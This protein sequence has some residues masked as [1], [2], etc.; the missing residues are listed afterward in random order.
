MGA[1]QSTAAHSCLLAA[2]G[3]SSSSVA[4]NGDLLFSS[5]VS[6]YNLNIPVAPIAVTYP[7]SAQ[8]VAKIVKCAADYNLK[9]QAYS[10][11]HSYGNYGLGGTDGAVVVNMKHFR[12]FSMDA[13][14]IATAGPGLNLGELH[15][16]LAAEGRAIAHGT[17]RQV[18]VGGHLTI[19]GLGTMSREWGMALDHV[20]EAQVVLANSSIVRASETENPDVFW[21]IKGAAASFGIVTEFKLLTHATLKNAIQYT[22]QLN[23]G[24]TADRA[25]LFKDWQ[26]LVYTPNIT[27][28]FSSELVLFEKS[29]LLSGF[30]FGTREEF[31]EFGLEDKFPIRN[32]GTV[33]QLS[34]WAGMV[35]SEAENLIVSAIGGT[36]AS[37]YAKS[38]VFKDNQ[39]IPDQDVDEMFRYLD[40]VNKGTPAWFVIFD[41]EG[42]AVNDYS[43]TATAYPHRDVIV[44]MESYAISLFGPVP[45]A[46]KQ[47][48]NGLHSV[49]TAN[50]T[51]I[52]ELGAYPG[53]VDPYLENAQAEYWG[54]NLPRL[55]DIKTSIDPQDVFHNPQSVRVNAAPH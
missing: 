27:R 29:A 39:S 41:L 31:A 5:H 24:S 32:S 55:Q 12:Q 30:Y 13:E 44:L 14:D 45:P 22:Y 43:T 36:P 48:L 11:G 18:G 54:V 47:F 16:K 26:K 1:A 7:E 37:F 50:R 2:V 49:I 40:T 21:A 3:N 8:Q 52:A 42:G 35:T 19:G 15:D 10:G 9:V 38:M 20:I 23:F 28:K 4:F 25:Q 33:L 34:D 6:R 53:F 17:C 46:T 51:D